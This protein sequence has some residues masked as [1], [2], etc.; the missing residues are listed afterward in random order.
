MV[1]AALTYTS[2]PAEMVTIDPSR[3]APP[4]VS[5]RNDPPWIPERDGGAAMTATIGMTA[6]GAMNGACGAFAATGDRGWPKYELKRR[7]TMRFDTVSRV[8]HDPRSFERTL[9]GGAG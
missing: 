2:D 9:W 8:V 1:A 4:A 6:T 5:L 3:H 7:A